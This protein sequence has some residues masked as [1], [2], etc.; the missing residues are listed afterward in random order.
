MRKAALPYPLKNLIS[1]VGIDETRCNTVSAADDS[2]ATYLDKRYGLAIAWLKSH[3]RACGDV[4]SVPVRFE[5][6]K[7]ELWI[8]LNEMIV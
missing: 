4:E 7:V 5:P 6:V 8:R 3:R 1:L 2:P